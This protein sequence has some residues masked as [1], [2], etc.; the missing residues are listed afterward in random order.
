MRHSLRVLPG[1][2]VGSYEILENRSELKWVD[3]RGES[4]VAL[5][6]RFL[7]ICNPE[8]NGLLELRLVLNW[9]EDAATRTLER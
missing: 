5:D 3:G 8:R 1:T 9:F 4:D 7:L 2:R 6:G